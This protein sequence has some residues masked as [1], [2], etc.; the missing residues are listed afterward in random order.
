MAKKISIVIVSYNVCQLLDECLQSVQRALEGIEGDVFVVDNASD[1]GTVEAVRHL[2][3]PVFGVQWHPE[4]M[5]AP[6]DGWL[7]LAR[8]LL[9]V[10]AV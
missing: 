2:S 4:R 7:L 9:D 1:D 10:G 8:W 5:R 3:L 6:T